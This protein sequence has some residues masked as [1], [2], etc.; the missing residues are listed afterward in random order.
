ML[1]TKKVRRLA[2]AQNM[3]SAYQLWKAIEEEGYQTSESQVR[4][5]WTGTPD[6][7]LSTVD[8]LCDVLRCEL[9]AITTR[10]KKRNGR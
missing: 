4:R 3:E 8:M 9:P 7:K 2:V 10:P 6:P 5:L 1:D